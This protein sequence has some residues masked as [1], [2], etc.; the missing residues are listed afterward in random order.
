M[1]TDDVLSVWPEMGQASP[2][3]N[4]ERIYLAWNLKSEREKHN[5][6][7]DECASLCI[8]ILMYVGVFVV[9][10]RGIIIKSNIM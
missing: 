1:V 9:I 5:A 7:V 2:W 4:V 3:T 10:Y 8:G 6:G